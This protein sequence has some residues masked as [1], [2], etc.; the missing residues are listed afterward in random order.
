MIVKKCARGT[1]NTVGAVSQFRIATICFGVY[2]LVILFMYMNEKMDVVSDWSSMHV[3]IHYSF[4]P[5]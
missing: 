5:K 4:D 2:K 1:N 3:K